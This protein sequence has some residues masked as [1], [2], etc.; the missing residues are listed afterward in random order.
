[1]V[2]AMMDQ[3]SSLFVER[4]QNRRQMHIESERETAIVFDA[5]LL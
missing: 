1:M 2:K 5:K 3:V 4:L